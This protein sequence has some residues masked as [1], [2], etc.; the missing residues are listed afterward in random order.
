METMKSYGVIYVKMN[1]QKIAYAL[2]FLTV[3]KQKEGIV[4]E[5]LGESTTYTWNSFCFLHVR[6]HIQ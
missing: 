4:L 1:L 6:S 2:A 3:G 5:K